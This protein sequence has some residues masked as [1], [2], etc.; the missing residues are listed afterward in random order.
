MLI[1]K[2]AAEYRV[3]PTRIFGN[4]RLTGLWSQAHNQPRIIRWSFLSDLIG[5]YSRHTW[6]KWALF[7]KR[8]GVATCKKLNNICS[9]WYTIN[10][11]IKDRPYPRGGSIF[12]TNCSHPRQTGVVKRKLLP[13]DWRKS[14]FYIF[15]YFF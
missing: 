15:N 10:L 1:E 5:F 12:E 13:Q 4:L 3:L 7:L 6:K 11:G 8:K 14:N 2:K 9:F